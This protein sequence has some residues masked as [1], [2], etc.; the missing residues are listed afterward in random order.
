NSKSTTDYGILRHYNREGH[1]LGEFLPHSSFAQEP[2]GPNIG[3]W[4]VTASTNRIGFTLYIHSVL[5]PGVQQRPGQWTEVDFEGKIVR[6]LELP[7]GW[8]VCAFTANGTV[9][10]ERMVFDSSRGT[11]RP[12]PGV[13]GGRLNGADGDFLAF[14]IANQN[15][16]R[17]TPLQ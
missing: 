17:R 16:V 6:T 4:H 13:P 10:A 11:W 9:Y 12:I 14:K 15:V 1:L 5:A 2:I 8:E 3:G 7:R